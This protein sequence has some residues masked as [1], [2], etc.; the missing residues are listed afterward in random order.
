[1]VLYF[2]LMFFKFI[3]M[4]SVSSTFCLTA[5]F[6]IFSI[7]R[8]DVL[9]M[10]AE[11]IPSVTRIAASLYFRI[12]RLPHVSGWNLRGRHHFQCVLFGA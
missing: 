8:S 7:L 5:L 11:C 2:A 10:S 4:A 9:F 3:V 1:M 12:R 6:I